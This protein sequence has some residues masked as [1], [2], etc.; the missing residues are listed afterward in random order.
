MQGAVGYESRGPAPLFFLLPSHWECLEEH[1]RPRLSS[2]RSSG[3]SIMQVLFLSG[4][5]E[6]FGLGK[7]PQVTRCSHALLCCCAWRGL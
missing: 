1:W 6:P 7:L 4:T 3:T 2:W 5:L